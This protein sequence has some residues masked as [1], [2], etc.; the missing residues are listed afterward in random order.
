LRVDHFNSNLVL[1]SKGST[2]EKTDVS[3]APS[4]ASLEQKSKT[5]DVARSLSRKEILK[6]EHDR[7][8][9]EVNERQ[10]ELERLR[11]IWKE[12]AKHEFDRIR[13]HVVAKEKEEARSKKEK[14]RTK[15]KSR[16]TKKRRLD[17]PLSISHPDVCPPDVWDLIIDLGF[18]VLSSKEV[19][20]LYG[21]K[22][23]KNQVVDEMFDP[24]EPDYSPTSPVYNPTSPD[25]SPSSP[26]YDPVLFA[27]SPYTP[28]YRPTSPLFQLVSSRSYYSDSYRSDSDC[29]SKTNSNKSKKRIDPFKRSNKL[30]LSFLTGLFSLQ[31]LWKFT[32]LVNLART[33]KSALHNFLTSP[34]SRSW[35]G[36]VRRAI[37]KNSEPSEADSKLSSIFCKRTS[38]ANPLVPKRSWVEAEKCFCKKCRCL[39]EHCRDF[40]N[41]VGYD[42][43]STSLRKKIVAGPYREVVKQKSRRELNREETKAK[44]IEAETYEWP[45]QRKVIWERDRIWPEMIQYN[46]H[47]THFYPKT[48][49]MINE[50]ERKRQEIE[51]ALEEKKKSEKRKVEPTKSKA[52]VRS[53]RLPKDNI[54]IILDSKGS[55]DEKNKRENSDGSCSSS[56]SSSSSEDSD[57]VILDL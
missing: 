11:T 4:F 9:K 10:E 14:E 54:K 46:Q 34:D 19:E 13:D 5:E 18:T 8:D 47:G 40:D 22:D 49:D 16:A 43:S 55:R 29:D 45:P 57:C 35:Y 38:K 44:K 6:Q 37:L 52:I 39:S 33:C 26:D 12:Q 31:H 24:L 21:E 25:Y 3:S 42:V 7:I 28:S 20:E 15:R 32:D 53:R 48:M 56:Y 41:H 2:K 51:E 17:E 50:S 30:D 36:S 27:R 23:E 1:S